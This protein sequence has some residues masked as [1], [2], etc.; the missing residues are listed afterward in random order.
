MSRKQN[1][2]K[3]SIASNLVLILLKIFVGILTGSVSIVSEAIHSIMDLFAAIV[4]F[5][6][7]KIA[8]LP[9]DE[10]HPYGH[11]KVEN[12][13]GVIEA[14]LVFAASVLIIIGAAKKIISREPIES[15]GVGFIVMFIS[16]CVN[17]VVSKVLYKVAREEESVAI[18]ADA[19]HL[20]VD[21]YTSLGVG[22]GLL[23]IWLTGWTILDPILAIL[24]ALF[25]L[26]EAWE[27]LRK[28]FKPLI[29]ESL[30]D[31]DIRLIKKSVER[32]K[33]VCID[34]HEIRTRRSG[35]IKHIDFHLSLPDN[36]TM[37][38][39]HDICDKIEYDIEKKI[40][41][42]KVLIHTE[43]CGVSRESLQKKAGNPAKKKI[44]KRKNDKRK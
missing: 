1:Y 14:L 2:A 19:L 7:V 13:S 21:V 38:E 25:I 29:D 37:K 30:S 15:I 41:N 3:L 5:F 22:V 39:A 34:V 26:K 23:L 31:E 18:E 4:A 28:A 35:K 33:D 44:I 20:K 6:S 11:E 16:S 8:D 36:I 24:I 43:A 10:N 32:Y 12:I 17:A 27:M 9:P 42:T 40:R